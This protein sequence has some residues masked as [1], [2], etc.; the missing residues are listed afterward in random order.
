MCVYIH[1]Y[2]IYIYVRLERRVS[3]YICVYLSIYVQDM[4]NLCDLIVVT[5]SIVGLIRNELDVSFL[6]AFRAFR[7]VRVVRRMHALRTI[8]NSIS[9]A[10]WPVATAFL[11]LGIVMALFAVAAVQL[12]G[13]ITPKQFGSFSLACSTLF[14]VACG[15]SWVT[16]VVWPITQKGNKSAYLFFVSYYMVTSMII[17]NIII[18]ILLD[19]FI[20]TA[21]QEK[22]NR[23]IGLYKAFEMPLDPLLTVLSSFSTPRE[24]KDSIDDIFTVLDDDDQGKLSYTGL[25]DGLYRLNLGRAIELS[26]EDWFILTDFG[27][28]C[29]GDD[30]LSRAAFARMLRN[31]L[32]TFIL[33]RAQMSTVVSGD[34][35]QASAIQ[36]LKLMFVSME[37]GSSPPQHV[38]EHDHNSPRDVQ[39]MMHSKQFVKNWQT[40][41]YLQSSAQNLRPS[42]GQVPT[43]VSK[44]LRSQLS[45]SMSAAGLNRTRS[46]EAG[47]HVE[48]LSHL[49]KPLQ[50]RRFA[51]RASLP[52]GMS[53]PPFQSSFRSENSET[54]FEESEVGRTQSDGSEVGE[55]LARWSARRYIYTCTR[56]YICTYVHTHLRYNAKMVYCLL[57]PVWLKARRS[58]SSLYPKDKSIVTEHSFHDCSL[59][60][61]IFRTYNGLSHH[62][63]YAFMYTYVHTHGMYVYRS[64]SMFALYDFTATATNVFS[65]KYIQC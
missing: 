51:R 38:E 65:A 7:V 24:L 48:G 57:K 8:M 33:R 45:A 1:T 9:H 58:I 22:N 56:I 5:M 41:A 15:D 10:M 64:Y 21:A 25:R 31:Q 11:F 59:D 55:G 26:P 46:L 30:V 37:S 32:S 2:I 42:S 40:H 47:S 44:A 20:S 29:D 16:G 6:R 14:Q 27:E 49:T 53:K 12:Y 61:I 17:F 50:E 28:L 35:S 43:K 19:E 36:M 63:T 4:W 54:I 23:L 34:N 13:R 62:S 60:A 3:I 39:Q 18:A 52:A